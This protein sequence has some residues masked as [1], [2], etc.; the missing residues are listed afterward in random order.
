MP[1]AL[2]TRRPGR[3]RRWADDAERKR[4]YR[5]RKAADL[6]EPLRLREART[7]AEAEAATARRE[8]AAAKA[9]SERW[10]RR[11]ETAQRELAVARA[12]A[13]RSRDRAE[14]STAERDE[15]RRLLRHKLH[16]AGHAATA[17]RVRDDPHALLA[18]IAE[19]HPELDK[20]RRENQGLRRMLGLPPDELDRARQ[21]AWQPRPQR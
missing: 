10:R 8:A 4:A 13:R 20:V 21:R 6:A 18:I 17:P 2:P 12:Q 16:L 11:A 5:Q 15:A 9:E 14:R 19:L 3:P 1:S 7:S